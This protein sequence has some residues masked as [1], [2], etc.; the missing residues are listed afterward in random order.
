MQTVGQ[1]LAVARDRLSAES[2]RLDAEV[3]LAHVTDHPR[4]WVLAHPD[5]VLSADQAAAYEVLLTRRTAGEPVAYLTGSREFYGQTFR[6]TPAVL[7]PRPETE[8]LVEAVL[9]DVSTDDTVL[10]IGTGSG[11]VAITI[12][13]ERSDM[14]VIATDFSEEA[15]HVAKSNARRHDLWRATP[16]EGVALVR[17]CLSFTTTDLLPDVSQLDPA[18]TLIAA[19]LPYVADDAYRDSPALHHEPALAL[20][21][22]PDGLAVINRLLDQLEARRFQPKGLYLEIDP[23]H[24]ATLKKRAW[25]SVRVLPDLAGRD[26]VLIF[27]ATV[28]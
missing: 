2:A 7:V 5:A 25:G 15:L 27:S 14:R 17:P 8:A 13:R 4:S 18:T 10:D 28:G 12:A 11:V 6:V 19:N 9:G 20:R 26:R 23:G 3:L 1:A 16:S 24:V 22:G 21:G